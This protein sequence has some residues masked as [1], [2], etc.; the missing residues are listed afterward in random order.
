MI[1]FC[2]FTPLWKCAGTIHKV[3]VLT[4]ILF[5]H[6][7]NKG[8][9]GDS[10][11]WQKDDL[12][13]AI[14]LQWKDAYKDSI[15]IWWVPHFSCTSRVWLGILCGT[16]WSTC[17]NM[18]SESSWS[19]SHCQTNWATKFP[20]HVLCRTSWAIVLMILP[21]NTWSK[22]FMVNNFTSYSRILLVAGSHSW[23]LR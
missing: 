18:W 3:K 19:M 11:E 7:S 17:S 9:T 6:T 14:H 15:I 23:G 12:Y 20:E 16:I 2:W 8:M 13:A 10:L 22:A 21:S 1:D 5:C 4:T